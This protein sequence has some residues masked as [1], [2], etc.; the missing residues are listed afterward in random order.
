MGCQPPF[1][2][3]RDAEWCGCTCKCLCPKDCYTSITE[4]W[5]CEY[6]DPNA[7]PTNTPTPTGTPTPTPTGTNTPTPTPT[8]TNTPT[9]T[10]TRTNTPTPTPTRTNTPTPTP[11]PTP[12]R[13]NT[14]TP[15]PT[16]TN[17]PTPTGV[18]SECVGW[19]K[20]ESGSCLYT[21]NPPG[22]GGTP[23]PIGKTVYTGPSGQSN[24]MNFGMVAT[25]DICIDKIT[26]EKSISTDFAYEEKYDPNSAPT[27]FL[28]KPVHELSE[29]P[30]F[31]DP[32]IA[33]EF[34]F[35]VDEDGNFV[36]EGQNE[37]TEDEMYMLNVCSIPVGGGTVSVTWTTDGCCFLE[38]GEIC[39]TGTV[40][41]VISGSTGD[42][43]TTSV[44]G[45]SISFSDQDPCCTCTQVSR[46]GV[47]YPD[48]CPDS[49]L[50]ARRTMR[51]GLKRV[52]LNTKELLKRIKKQKRNR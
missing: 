14:P 34:I 10:P 13:T 18:C 20:N 49:P 23:A 3:G 37:Y 25:K 26:L 9:P 51:Q 50:V 40:T 28:E 31:K 30:K 21:G 52:H 48:P 46:T 44:S 35:R 43:A 45:M 42:C 29:F 2:N 7:P 6:V 1:P 36:E 47:L 22:N 41:A 24:C 4:V 27:Y 39:G 19:W 15:T 16:R 38:S 11:T 5:K 12:T 32:I 33:R 8:G 17:T